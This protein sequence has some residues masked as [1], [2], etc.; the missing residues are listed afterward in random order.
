MQS[1]SRNVTKRDGVGTSSAEDLNLQQQ[2]CEN[3]KSRNPASNIPTSETFRA[4]LDGELNF[5]PILKDRRKVTKK[6]SRR[7]T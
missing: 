1:W 3:L 2:C 4:D 5:K 6:N 7:S